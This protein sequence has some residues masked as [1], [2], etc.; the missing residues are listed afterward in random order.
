MVS[1]SESDGIKKIIDFTESNWINSI[2]NK[3]NLFTL[4]ILLSVWIPH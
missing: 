3:I 2:L 4:K 1:N